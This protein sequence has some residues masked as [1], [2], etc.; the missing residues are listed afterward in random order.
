VEKDDGFADRVTGDRDVRAE[1]VEGH[2][3]MLNSR[4][5]EMLGNHLRPS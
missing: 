4:D 3:R 2:G 5:P 1:P